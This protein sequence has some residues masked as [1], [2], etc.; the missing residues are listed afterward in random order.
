MGA[1]HKVN[2][3]KINHNFPKMTMGQYWLGKIKLSDWPEML[4]KSCYGFFFLLTD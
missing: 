4:S 2:S 3:P 1:N